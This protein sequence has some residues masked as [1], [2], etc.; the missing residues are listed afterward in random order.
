MQIDII[1]RTSSEMLMLIGAFLL[2]PSPTSAQSQDNTVSVSD[3]AN[4][5]VRFDNGKVR[6]YEVQLFKGKSTAIHEHTADNFAVILTTTTRANEPKGGERAVAPVTAGQVGFGSTAKGPYS[7]RVQATG[8]VPYRNI[9][10]EMLLA[11]KLGSAFGASKRPDP[12]V[13]AL[14]DNPRGRAYRLTLKPGATTPSFER[15]ANT[16]IVAIAGGR[17]SELIE[18]MEP[19]LWDSE[20]GSFRW[21]DE[22]KRLVIRND[23][24]TDVDLIEIEVF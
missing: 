9:T 22:S 17:T 13:V 5:K 2:F 23:G 1:R 6:I 7:H 3:E 18:G 10:L 16:L 14:Q 15:P 11:G 21:V 24:T 4:H 20:S 19:R 8:D 12:F